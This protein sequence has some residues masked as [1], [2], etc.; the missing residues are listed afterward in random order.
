[1]K[2]IN[3]LSILFICLIYSCKENN[4]PKNSNTMEKYDFELEKEF[5][6][7][8]ITDTIIKR[9]DTLI[10]VNGMMESGTFCNEYPPE[11]EFYM[12]QKTF[13]PNGMLESK[14]KF[15]GSHLKIGIWQYYDKYND[16]PL[17]EIT[18]EACPETG[19]I[20]TV[21]EIHGNTGEVLSKKSKEIFRYE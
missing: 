9:G 20:E 6:M 11:P 14:G 19:F 13:Y 3:F 5:R 17:W 2:A 12:I 8:G 16:Y 21:Y 10:F 1:M 7:R 4:N 18:I 15:T